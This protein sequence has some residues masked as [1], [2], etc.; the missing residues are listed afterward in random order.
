MHNRVAGAAL[1]AVLLL[2]FTPAGAAH[3]ALLE[4][5]LSGKCATVA[6][7]STTS[8]ADVQQSSCVYAGEQ[9]IRFDP[10]ASTAG[11]FRM[12]F[13]HS[14][15]CLEVAGA[16][17]APGANLE[18]ADCDGGTNQ[19]FELV[20]APAEAYEVV[21]RHSGLRVS[22]A[23]I[24]SAEGV[25]LV[26]EADVDGDHQ[27]WRLGNADGRDPSIYGRWSHVIPWPHIP[28]SAANLPD[29]RIL[30]FSGS[31]RETWPST[32]FTYSATWDPETG[33]ITEVTHAGHNMF[34]AHL[35][36]T[37]DGQVFVNGGRNQ[38]NSPWTSLF[39]Y[40]DNQWHAIENMPG[41]RWYPT[42]V[43]L[44]DGDMFTVVGTATNQRN[45]DRWDA[46]TGWKVMT[47]IDFTDP[48]LSYA[49]THD[50][51]L[52]W[53]LLHVAP[54]GKLFHS[55]PL[56]TVGWINTSGS[57]S[58]EDTGIRLTDWYHKHGTSIMYEKG[59]IL[60]AGGW[61]AGQN[62]TSSPRSM[63][64]DLNGPA[65]VITEIDPMNHARKFHNGVMLPDG[66]VLVIGGNTSGA[67]F[68]DS[69][70]VYAA[71]IW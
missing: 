44:T 60:N 55:G 61:I 15:K 10:A 48:I 16:S 58:Y 53:T 3:T 68:S 54:Q 20:P 41:G 13:T 7:G 49:S 63:T 19:Q 39:N 43:A 2:S 22:L 11:V 30:T 17:V 47:G 40:A 42:T 27:R 71:E 56:P 64:I 67:K 1:A 9:Q 35:A 31:E 65:P 18:Q 51:Y 29:G 45:P 32:E 33:A 70:A 57:G 62:T 66:E 6:G 69:G 14:D 21:A 25:S 24:S 23:S 34:C 4:S 26:Q 46:R 5:V 12:R 38:V 8:G 59:R 36:M 52:W 50:E 28:V 37:Q